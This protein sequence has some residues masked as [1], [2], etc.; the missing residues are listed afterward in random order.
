MDYNLTPK[1]VL[2]LWN[3]IF[4]GAEPM[5]SKVQPAITRAERQVLEKSGFI[6]LDKRGRAYHIVLTDLAWAWAADNMDAPI[7]QSKYSTI[8]L[9]GVLSALKRHI[10]L[11]T[12]S[13]AEFAC[14]D[15]EYNAAEAAETDVDISAAIRQAYLSASGGRLCVRVRLADLANFVDGVSKSD[16]DYE[17]IRMQREGLYGLVLWSLDDPQDINPPDEQAAVDIGGIKRHIVYME[18]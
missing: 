1:H 12:F 7:S 11:N 16:L 10:D 13:L 5:V 17:L 18:N 15:D 8:A 2:V 9:A 3:L 6:E 4:T 14:P